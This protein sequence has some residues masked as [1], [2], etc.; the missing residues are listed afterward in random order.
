MAAKYA[1]GQNVMIKKGIED[2]RMGGFL[3]DVI[4]L[5]EKKPENILYMVRYKD[6]AMLEN[7]KV[8]T[9]FWIEEDHLVEAVPDE[10]E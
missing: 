8:G 9:F 5:D 4:Q 3:C 6:T 10:T 2:S 1:V 7:G